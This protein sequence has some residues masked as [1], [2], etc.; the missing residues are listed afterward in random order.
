MKESSLK[1]TL[2]KILVWVFAGAL[3]VQPAFSDGEAP[4]AASA[5]EIA[6][7]Q[8]PEPEST[9]EPVAEPARVEELAGSA[10]ETAE[11]APESAT[12]LS[13]APEPEEAHEALTSSAQTSASAELAPAA[14]SE[15]LKNRDPFEGLNRSTFKFNRGFEKIFIDPVVDFYG[16]ATPDVMQKG[17][18]NGFANLGTPSV[19]I[20]KLL[21]GEPL[22][23]GVASGRF[24]VNSTLG[25]VGLFDPAQQMGLAK[26]HADFGQ[27]LYVYGLH[28]GPYMVVPLLGPTTVRDSIGFLVDFCFRPDTYLLTPSVTVFL[29]GGHGLTTKENVQ[30]ALE[31]LRAD[32]V[33]EYALIRSLYLMHR[34]S[35]LRGGVELTEEELEEVLY[36]GE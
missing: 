8:V 24:V 29:I 23:A 2:F 30:D 14:E 13:S 27:T 6:A 32:T 20:N 1:S 18:R 10:S 31:A 12:A 3:P 17:A 33:D 16:W 9:F 5:P 35:Q 28:S 26:Q 15:P 22:A 19:A 21:Q 34:A 36:F 25:I 11:A 4:P 7:E